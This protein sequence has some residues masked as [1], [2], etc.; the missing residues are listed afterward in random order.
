VTDS[1]PTHP[2][3]QPDGQVRWQ[4]DGQGGRQQDGEGEWQRPGGE[5]PRPSIFSLEGKPAPGLY[6]VAWILSLVGAGLIFVGLMAGNPATSPPLVLS[7]LVALG[8]GLST[9]AGYQILARSRRPPSAYR[10]PSPL[11]LFGI[12]VAVTSVVVGPLALLRIVNLATTTG[13]LAALIVTALAYLA[14]VT[15]FVLRSGA[16]SWRDMGWPG[17]DWRP[18]KALEDAA[19]AIALMAPAFIAVNLMGG[20]LASGLGVRLESPLPMPRTSAEVIALVLAAVVVAPIGEEVF[21][22][23]FALTAWQRDL[24]VRAALVRSSVF[25]AVVHLANLTATT[26]REGFLLAF[27]A[28]VVYLPVAFLLGWLFQRRGIVA[29]IAGHAAANGTGLLLAAL[30][31]RLVQSG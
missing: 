8:A 22:R 11:I 3:E 25:F 9:A 24:G 15:T 14:T 1:P 10:G 26:A 18:G 20:V 17:P 19:A 5:P 30:A 12:V 7:G 2:F 28:F 23:G 6:F 21:F 31:E 27:V 13:A 16:L 4:P 29:S